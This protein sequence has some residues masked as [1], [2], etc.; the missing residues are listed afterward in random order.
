MAVMSGVCTPYTLYHRQTGAWYISI[1]MNEV[2]GFILRHWCRKIFPSGFFLL[3]NT[4]YLTTN[5][6]KFYE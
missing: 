4:S 1:T 5:E 6:L 2:K 3:Y